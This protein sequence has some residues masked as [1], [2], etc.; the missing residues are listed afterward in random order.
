MQ[1]QLCCSY[2]QGIRLTVSIRGVDEA[3]SA[4]VLDWLLFAI[5]PDT[6]TQPFIA[7]DGRFVVRFADATFSLSDNPAKS[8]SI[9][10]HQFSCVLT[11]IRAS[12]FHAV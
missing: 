2:S 4:L 5:E 12:A 7:T 8:V 1:V 11:E 10:R 6:S 9:V 3:N